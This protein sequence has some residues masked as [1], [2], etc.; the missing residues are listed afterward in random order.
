MESA[1]T[2]TIVRALQELKVATYD[3]IRWFDRT[4]TVDSYKK[5]LWDMESKEQVKR[6]IFQAGKNERYVWLLPWYEDD[7]NEKIDELIQ[8][9]VAHLAQSPSTPGELRQYFRERHPAYHQIG[10]LALKTAVSNGLVLQHK[11]NDGIWK[12]IYHLPET[13]DL[14]TLELRVLQ[15]INDNGFAFAQDISESLKITRS[16]AYT[17]LAKLAYD[18]KIT[19][20]KITWNYAR[21]VP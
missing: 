9:I 20:F 1:I 11:F 19:R 2:N 15:S 13:N 4:Y 18:G 17:L 10:Y 12:T 21:N 14:Q 6:R 5:V 8:E 3:S 16:L 7:A